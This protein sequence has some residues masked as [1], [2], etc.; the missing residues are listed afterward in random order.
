MVPRDSPTPC[1]V[2]PTSTD[3]RGAGTRG[4]KQMYQNADPVP[5]PAATLG[6]KAAVGR[7]NLHRRVY[8]QMRRKPRRYY[9]TPGM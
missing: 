4:G 2:M 6:G 3:N 8:R 9:S 1:P 7:E 5:L